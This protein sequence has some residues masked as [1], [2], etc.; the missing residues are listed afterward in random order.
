M[1]RLRPYA[2]RWVVPGSIPGRV[3]GNFQV[4]YSLHWHLGALVTEIIPR[5]FLGGKARPALWLYCRI[6]AKYWSRVEAEHYT[7]PSESSWLVMGKLIS[8]PLLEGFWHQFAL[9]GLAT[10]HHHIIIVQCVLS[11]CSVRYLNSAH[12]WTTD[13]RICIKQPTRCIKYP[14]SI[15]A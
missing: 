6:C 4:D 13:S 7:P 8:I 10:I 5:N 11:A 12:V 3:L 2:T 1:T 9:S 14:T 15:L